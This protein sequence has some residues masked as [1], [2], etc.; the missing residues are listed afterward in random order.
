MLRRNSLKSLCL[1][2]LVSLTALSVGNGTANAAILSDNLDNETGFTEIISAT[3]GSRRDFGRMNC[4]QCFRRQRSYLQATG[5][6]QCRSIC[7]PMAGEVL[8]LSLDS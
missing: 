3:R 8:L 5:E 1:Y 7:T 4:L 2:T 6:E